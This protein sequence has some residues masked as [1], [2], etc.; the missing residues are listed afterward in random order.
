M[1]KHPYETFWIPLLLGTASVLTGLT[2]SLPGW[3]AISL[4]ILSAILLLLAGWT[5]YK[6][7]NS[8]KSFRSHG[9]RGGSAESFGSDNTAIG[10]NGGD[11]NGSIGGAGGSVSVK[12]KG[13]IAKGG[14]GGAG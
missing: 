3:A 10:G 1:P 6:I 4:W 2:I 13:S 14:N 9:G 11:A 5:A 7:R 8:P 12:G